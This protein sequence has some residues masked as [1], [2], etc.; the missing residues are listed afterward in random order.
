[1]RS[2]FCF[3]FAIY[4]NGLTGYKK[5]I[6]VLQ[7]LLYFCLKKKY[8]KIENKLKAINMLKISKIIKYFIQNLKNKF[9]FSSY[10]YCFLP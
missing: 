4:P 8:K 1:M 9:F 10:I 6:L 2:K 5:I 3:I 7:K